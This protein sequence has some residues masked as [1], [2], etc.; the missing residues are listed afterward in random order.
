MSK[1]LLYTSPARGHLYPMMDVA[2]ALREAGH[3]VIVHTLASEGERIARAGLEARPLAPAI[4]AIP[5][6]DF[7]S[8]GSLGQ[9]KATVACWWARAPHEVRDLRVA[10]DQIDPDMLVVDVNAWGATAV[11][12]ASGLPWASFLPYC[13]PVPSPDTPVFGPGFP[14]PRHAL[15]RLRDRLVGRAV[16][17]AV[18]DV[19]EDLSALRAKHGLAPVRRYGDLFLRAERVLYR[20]A[21]PFD[22]PR[23]RWPD[24][25]RAIGPGLWAPPGHPP[26]WLDELPRPR[27]LVN[28]S[29]ELQ[30]DG[31]IVETALEALAEEPGSVVV[32]TSALDPE[33][34]EPPNERVRIARFLPHAQVVPE[35]D[36]VVTHGGMGTTQRAL[37]HGVPVC[38]V[39]WGRDQNETARRVEVCGAGTC[40]PRGRLDARRLR[41]AVREART[42]APAA[43]RV[44]RAFQEAGGAPRAVEILEE[45]LGAPAPRPVAA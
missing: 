17:G 19:L 25:I 1:V 13:L 4:E 43:R 34:F 5:I 6:E 3:R 42:R 22:Y 20:T 40:L 15:D 18:R 10:V 27:V 2:L 41:A 33:R 35:V 9:L 12:E 21:E 16:H 24:P 29:T 45:L 11:A 14:P 30:E 8:P 37:A 28:V 23:R 36:A 32:T 31:A 39:P 26:A 7:K 44:A 38:V